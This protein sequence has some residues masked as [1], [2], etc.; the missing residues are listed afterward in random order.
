MTQTCFRTATN[1]QLE[2][3]VKKRIPKGMQ[4]TKQAGF[5]GRFAI[6]SGK[7]TCVAQL[8]E[9]NVDEQLIKL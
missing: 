9:Q 7:A 2:T 8:F 3:A 6:H 1:D 4:K 5:N